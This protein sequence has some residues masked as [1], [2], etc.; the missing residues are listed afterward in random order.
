MR[1]NNNNSFIYL[2][3]ALFIA[4][5]LVHGPSKQLIET[6]IQIDIARLESQLAAGKPVGYSQAWLRLQLKKSSK[7]SG[8]NL[9]PGPLAFKSNALTTWS[10]HHNI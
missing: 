10:S 5:K 3:L 7:Q 8:R 1:D 9:K 6:K 2:G 4:Q